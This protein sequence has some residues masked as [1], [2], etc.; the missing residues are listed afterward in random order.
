[1]V[2]QQYNLH[3]SKEYLYGAITKQEVHHRQAKPSICGKISKD[4]ERFPDK[5]TI[6]GNFKKHESHAT[7]HNRNKGIWVDPEYPDAL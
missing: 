6:V 3:R 5:N 2:E 1:M 4:K 7:S